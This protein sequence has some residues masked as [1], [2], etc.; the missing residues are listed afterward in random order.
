MVQRTN[1]T[2]KFQIWD[3]EVAE[4][5]DL[6]DGQ[7]V[8]AYFECLRYRQ[9]LTP[10]QPFI[11]RTMDVKTLTGLSQWS[12]QNAR[13]V[14]EGSGWIKA[15]ASGRGFE[16]TIT[17]LAREATRHIPHKKDMAQIYKKFNFFKSR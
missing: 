3:D 2:R 17:D 5:F 7:K 14:L 11:V 13:I 15:K 9:Q 10:G 6:W 4:C 16:V 12:Q 8:A 1:K